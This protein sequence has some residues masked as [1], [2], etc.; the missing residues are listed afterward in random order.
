MATSHLTT[1]RF[2]LYQH[3]HQQWLRALALYTDQESYFSSLLS[4]VCDSTA[5][6]SI[7]NQS[8]SFRQWFTGLRAQMAELS[9]LIEMEERSTAKGT[10]NW[11]R[12]QEID[13]RHR[14]MRSGY[15][16]LEQQF[17]TVRQQF[18]A[19]ITPYVQ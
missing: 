9:E 4:H 19:F 2:A 7:V 17:I 3:E 1:E 13:E 6:Y 16:M 10:P 14:R 5:D 18:Y 8:V 11:Q 15:Q 12:R